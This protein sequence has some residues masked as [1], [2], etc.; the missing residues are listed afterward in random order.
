MGRLPSSESCSQIS[1][2]WR[3]AFHDSSASGSADALSRRSHLD[4]PP[5]GHEAEPRRRTIGDRVP[6]RSPEGDLSRAASVQG[7]SS[8]PRD[9]FTWAGPCGTSRKIPGSRSNSIALEFWSKAFH[10]IRD[11]SA[12]GMLQC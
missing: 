2:A 12:H 8:W 6:D 11:L 3:A 4:D 10:I 5:C 9:R 7:C 1:E